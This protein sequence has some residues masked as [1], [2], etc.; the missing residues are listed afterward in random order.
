MKPMTTLLL[1]M[2]VSLGI[3]FFWDS[4]PLVGETVNIFLGPT[5]GKLL[6]FNI[7]TGMIIVTGIITFFIS[8]I[9]KYTVDNDQLRSL[10][11]EQ[12][13]LQGKMKEFKD[14][15]E[16]LMELQKKQLEFIPQTMQLTMRPLIYTAIPIILFFRWFNDYFDALAEPVKIFGFFTWFWA[17]LVFAII[18]SI[19]FRKM[20]KL[21]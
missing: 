11:N 15:P 9:Q 1:V 10:K 20:L 3:A 16:K 6:D 14:N 18:F 5:A 12:K 13:I 4:A 8:L 17:Y 2:V 7:T 19:I 21:P